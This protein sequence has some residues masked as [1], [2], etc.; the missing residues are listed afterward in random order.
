MR[1]DPVLI[2]DEAESIGRGRT[3]TASRFAA[4]LAMIRKTERHRP[5]LIGHD[6][7]STGGDR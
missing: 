6:I 7:D 3:D 4:A 5:M 2:F 1:S